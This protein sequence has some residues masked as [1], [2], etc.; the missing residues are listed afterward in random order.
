MNVYFEEE[1]KLAGVK[2]RRIDQIRSEVT[3]YNVDTKV[4]Q[5]M[6]HVVGEP[7]ASQRKVLIYESFGTKIFVFA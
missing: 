4:M 3:P 6:V 1:E 5:V 2:T 7:N